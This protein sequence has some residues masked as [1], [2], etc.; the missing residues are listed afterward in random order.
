MNESFIES[1]KVWLANGTVFGV[2]TLTDIEAVGKVLLIA[3]SLGYTI[4]K[5]M[6]DSK[7]S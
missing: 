6:Q 5:W 1:S 3:A 2:V 7:K 4:W